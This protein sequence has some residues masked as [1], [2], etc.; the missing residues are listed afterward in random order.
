MKFFFTNTIGEK[1]FE[2]EDLMEVEIVAKKYKEENNLLS[3]GIKVD[4]GQFFK[5]A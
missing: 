1:V 2:D 5:W 4:R 3:L